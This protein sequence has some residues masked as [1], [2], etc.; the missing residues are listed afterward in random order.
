MSHY[1]DPYGN[2]TTLSQPKDF[3]VVG[4]R[5]GRGQGA[6][7]NINLDLFEVIRVSLIGYQYADF[8]IDGGRATVDG[9]Y[10]ENDG[11]HGRWNQSGNGWFNFGTSTHKSGVFEL[12]NGGGGSW[13]GS[14]MLQFGSWMS[15]G[16]MTIQSHRL[17][18]NQFA[19]K[20]FAMVVEG[21]H[22]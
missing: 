4:F 20:W 5:H 2:L 8:R 14:Y 10:L 9:P 18:M 17:R 6:E 19:D 1:L 11:G 22:N 3:K 21:I 12:M 16:V 7:L 13:G 15:S